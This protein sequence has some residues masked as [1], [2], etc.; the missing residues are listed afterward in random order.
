MLRNCSAISSPLKVPSSTRSR[1]SEI[2][3]SIHSEMSGPIGWAACLPRYAFLPPVGEHGLQQT[4]G[5]ARV[6]RLGIDDGAAA[7]DERG[8]LLA[9]RRG[10][11]VPSELLVAAQLVVEP[12]ARQRHGHTAGHE[13]IGRQCLDGGFCHIIIA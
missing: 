10:S 8:A 4:Q 11:D 9:P 5:L 6:L 7:E 3:L 2:G 12:G 1:R 13:G